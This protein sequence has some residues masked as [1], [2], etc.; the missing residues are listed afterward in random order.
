MDNKI[1]LDDFLFLNN[2]VKLAVVGYFL[3]PYFIN[4]NL[5]KFSNPLL[6]RDYGLDYMSSP[7]LVRLVNKYANMPIDSKGFSRTLDRMVELQILNK[8]KGTELHSKS[9]PFNQQSN[10]YSL[11]ITTEITSLARQILEGISSSSA[12]FYLSIGD[13]HSSQSKINNSSRWNLLRSIKDKQKSKRNKNIQ[14]SEITEETGIQSYA[15]NPHLKALENALIIN[16]PPGNGQK[17][18][19]KFKFTNK[20]YEISNDPFLEI[21]KKQVSKY[22]IFSVSDIISK[23][24]TINDRKLKREIYKLEKQGILSSQ[25]RKNRE[26]GFYLTK[27][28]V[29]FYNLIIEPVLNYFETGNSNFTKFNEKALS[30]SLIKHKYYKPNL[31]SNHDALKLMNELPYFTEDQIAKTMNLQKADHIINKLKEEGLIRHTGTKIGYNNL[32]EITTHG[33]RKALK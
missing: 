16:N 22:S 20:A 17:R 3:E 25:N 27:V 9:K 23:F 6:G 4:S 18:N 10:Y 32:Y 30:K 12:N 8:T 19:L 11:N 24:I 26:K 13:V 28:G 33:E 7:D 15:I 29:Q 2:P 21:L 1:T 5:N 14:K 31:N